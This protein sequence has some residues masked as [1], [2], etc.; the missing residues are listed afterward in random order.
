MEWE[1]QEES[2]NVEDRRQFPVKAAAIG[3]GGL[4]IVLV[5]MFL[6]VNPQKLLDMFGQ[7][8]PAAEQG[9]PVERKFDPEEERLAS[10]TKVVLRDTE[11]VWDRLFRKMGKTYQV[12]TLVLFSGRVDSACGM[13]DSAV[14]PFYCPGDSKVYIDLSFYKDMERKLDA[15]GE[16]ARAYV[17]AHE[18]GHHVQRLLGYT[19][20]IEEIRSEDKNKR[21]VRLELQADYLAGVWAYYGK[22]KFKLNAADIKSAVHAAYEIGDDRLQS[23]ARGYVVPEKFTHGSSEQRQRWFRRGYETGDVDGA[24]QLLEL[25][26]NRL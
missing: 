6:G 13:A 19:A 22:E 2:S 24:R 16:F 7:G 15:P 12:P 14:G 21:S 1:G 4:I 18:V 26:Y 25:P 17:V 8:Q 10:F 5:A 11:V 23:K 20:R 3:G 9:A